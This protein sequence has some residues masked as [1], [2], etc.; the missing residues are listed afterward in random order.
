VSVIPK[1]AIISSAELHD[2][3]SWSE[4]TGTSK[5]FAVT[6]TWTETGLK[7]SNKP[8][9]ESLSYGIYNIP[10]CSKGNGDCTHTTIGFG[11]IVQRWV[12]GSLV[13]NGFMITTPA[14]VSSSEIDS[15]ET[16]HIPYLSVTYTTK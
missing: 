5:M 2:F 1:T 13:N 3:I 15:K 11:N 8:T 12:N 14:T 6:S 4:A 9:N 7:W 10:K 16:S